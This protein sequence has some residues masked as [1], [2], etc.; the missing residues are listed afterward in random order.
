MSTVPLVGSSR[1]LSRRRNDDL[2]AP[3]GPTT[4]RTSPGA[5]ATLM[6]ST[7]RLPPTA[8]DSCRVA[9]IGAG[10]GR[11]VVPATGFIAGS[12]LPMLAVDVAII[13]ASSGLLSGCFEDQLRDLFGM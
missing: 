6:S 12:A 2:P 10:C 7:R 11:T 3:L 5:T 8:R 1:R 9:S 4:A 13:A